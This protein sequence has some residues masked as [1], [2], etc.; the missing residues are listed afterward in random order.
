MASEI[1][2]VKVKVYFE[3][4]LD[5]RVDAISCKTPAVVVFSHLARLNQTVKV[6]NANNYERDKGH[7]QT[8]DA[9]PDVKA[10]DDEDDGQNDFLV[11]FRTATRTETDKEPGFEKV[12]DAPS[13]R[14]YGVSPAAVETKLAVNHL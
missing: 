3:N 12:A 5:I 14:R 9:K 2:N 4:N 11:V 1:S 13:R 6:R 10:S 7:G 8:F